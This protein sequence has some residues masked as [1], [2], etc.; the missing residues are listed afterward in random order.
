[1]PSATAAGDAAATSIRA[2]ILWVVTSATPPPS[3]PGCG[4]APA[5]NA[6][7]MSGGAAWGSLEPG[8][9]LSAAG[10]NGATTAS[11]DRPSSRIG[12]RW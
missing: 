5:D 1:M 7:A 11:L 10:W 6:A 12:G 9:F 4:A 2:A 3:P 8:R